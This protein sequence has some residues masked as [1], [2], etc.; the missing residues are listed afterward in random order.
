MS[1]YSG[2]VVLGGWLEEHVADVGSLAKL[3][4][5]QRLHDGILGDNL[6]VDQSGHDIA[7][8]DLLRLLFLHLLH[9][10]CHLGLHIHHGLIT[11]RDLWLL[12]SALTLLILPLCSSV[13]RRLPQLLQP[14]LLISSLGLCLLSR[15]LLHLLLFS[16]K[17][18]LCRRLS[19]CDEL[20]TRCLDGLLTGNRRLQLLQDVL[21]LAAQLLHFGSLFGSFELRLLGFPFTGCP[22]LRLCCLGSLFPAVAQLHSCILHQLAHHLARKN[23]L[24]QVLDC[25]LL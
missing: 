9:C 3:A 16:F 17:C 23:S 13:G 25:L 21:G 20:F 15:L 14:C 5:G 24:G 18:R 19:A 8:C 6:L 12:V 10:S 4:D 1:M 7:I 11:Q 22:R 2:L